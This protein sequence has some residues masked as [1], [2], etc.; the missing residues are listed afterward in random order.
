M[1]HSNPALVAG[2]FHFM[3]AGALRSLPVSEAVLLRGGRIIDP[4]TEVDGTGDVIVAEGRVQAISLDGPA[5]TPRAGITIIDCEGMIICPGLVDPHVHLRE[6]G[7]EN[8]ETIAS[9]GRAAVAGGYTTICC[10]PNTTPAIDLPSTVE[11]VQLRAQASSVARV[12]VAGA[13]TVGR[14][15][16]QLA[17]M[18]AMARVGAVAFTDD[19]E[20]VASAGMMGKVLAVCASL[21]KPFMQHCQD[22][23]LSEGGVMNAGVVSARLGLGGWPRVAEEVIIE[24]DIRLNLAHHCHYHAQHLSSGGSV[25]LIRRARH[26]GQ[27]VTAEVAPHHL[28]LTE[29]ACDQYDPVMKVNPPL[30]ADSDIR[31]LVEGVAD[32]TITVLGT[33]H[34]P[35]TPSE[36]A[37]DFASAPFGMIGMEGA[38]ALYA[39]ALVDSGAIDWPRLLAMMTIEPARLLR[40]DDRGI[41]CLRVGAPADVL[42]FD[43][44]RKWKIDPD[45]FHSRSRNCPFGGWTV[46]GSVREV[47]VGGRRAVA[48]GALAEANTRAV[49]HPNAV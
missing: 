46:K 35:H 23:T 5:A 22:P 37:R 1:E 24:R 17:P 26:A 45:A 2:L 32:G 15:G 33:D 19:G 34:A 6:P 29:D 40:V 49:G 48:N 16:E 25:E 13:A 47:F 3:H 11:F 7:A 31:L 36:K 20:C 28:L 12:L 39:K 41:G 30:R 9:G 21:G 43:A 18:G 14:K 4:A 44:A 27:P 38:L 10:M 8:K 42:V